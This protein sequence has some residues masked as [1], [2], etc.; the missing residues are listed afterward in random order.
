MR[1]TFTLVLA[2]VALLAFAAPVAFAQA[3]TP[4][5]T[6]TGLIDNLVNYNKNQGL[7]SSDRNTL[8]LF[9]NPQDKEFY[10]RTRGRFDIVG[11]LGKG[12]AVLGLEIDCVYGQTGAS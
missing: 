1:R 11:E 5:V 6:I 12:K 9:T 8:G 2:V 10:S 4:K 3:P 7:F